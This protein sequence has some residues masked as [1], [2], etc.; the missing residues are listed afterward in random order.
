LAEYPKFPGSWGR[1]HLRAHLP[2]GGLTYLPTKFTTRIYYFTTRIYYLQTKITTHIYYVCVGTGGGSGERRGRCVHP[3]HKNVQRFRGGLVFKAHRLC[4]SLNSR[5][6]QRRAPREMCTPS[7]P[8]SAR[9]PL[10]PRGTSPSSG[11]SLN[12]KKTLNPKP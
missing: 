5:R 11:W 4:V 6:R 9:R 3:L 2:R 1:V 10:T 7:G 8:P 12:P